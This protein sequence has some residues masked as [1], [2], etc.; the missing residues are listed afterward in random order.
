[1]TVTTNY[2]CG[3]KWQH[4]CVGRGD[5]FDMFLKAFGVRFRK[6]E[7]TKYLNSVVRV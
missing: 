6:K 5:C 2:L 7:R 4:V 1:M 3:Q